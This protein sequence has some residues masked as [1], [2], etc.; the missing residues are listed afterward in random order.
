MFIL[1]KKD[2]KDKR[3]SIFIITNKQI[4]MYD[5]IEIF[6]AKCSYGKMLAFEP[7]NLLEETY[8][9]TVF[10]G[11]YTPLGEIIEK[12]HNEGK[13]SEIMFTCQ[14]CK[15]KCARKKFFCDGY[16]LKKYNMMDNFEKISGLL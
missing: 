12:T 1:L 10:F 2:R 11:N 13:I 7:L 3:I 9:R 16:T 6:I 14:Y 8:I 5:D 15:I 4:I